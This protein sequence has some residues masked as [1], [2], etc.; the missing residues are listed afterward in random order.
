MYQLRLF[1]QICKFQVN[2]VKLHKWWLKFTVKCLKHKG[3]N[4][5]ID[6][7]NLLPKYKKLNRVNSQLVTAMKSNK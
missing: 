4:N 1:Q 5:K 7:K 6:S 3:H 2:K